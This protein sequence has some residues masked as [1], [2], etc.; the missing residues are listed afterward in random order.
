MTNLNLHNITNSFLDV[1]LVSLAS[2]TRA[3]EFEPRDHGGP[4]VVVQEGYDPNDTKFIAEEFILGRHGKWLS[5]GLFYHLP[6]PE[7][8]QEFI[9]STAAEIMKMMSNLSSKAEIIT[10]SEQTKDMALPLPD[11]MIAAFN[12]GRNPNSKAA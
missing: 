9:F 4:Y 11:D 3:R 2:W 8:Q 5:L 12:V 1:R 6:L 7:R 10:S